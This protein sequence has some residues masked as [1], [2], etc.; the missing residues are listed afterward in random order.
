L[1]SGLD[2]YVGFFFGRVKARILPMVG[3]HECLARGGHGLPKVSLGPVMPY[4]STPC[5]QTTPETALRLFQGWPTSRVCG[6]QPSSTHMDTPRRMPMLEG[7]IAGA[8]FGRRA[9]WVEIGFFW[10]KVKRPNTSEGS[11]MIGNDALRAA[12]PKPVARSVH[13]QP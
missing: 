13:D 8:R 3:G 5:R 12:I 11:L 10:G 1:G 2:V 4:P 7:T 6:L 9:Q